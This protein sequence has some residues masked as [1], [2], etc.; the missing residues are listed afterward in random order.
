MPRTQKSVLHA[1]SQDMVCI[2]ADR[3]T[4]LMLPLLLL[5]LMMLL[6]LLLL[7]LDKQRDGRRR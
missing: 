4:I 1:I 5:L 7:L 6:L 3:C 2:N